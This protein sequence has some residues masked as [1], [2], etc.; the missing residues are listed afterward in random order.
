MVFDSGQHTL[1][2]VRFAG[3]EPGTH[4]LD[5]ELADLQAH[6]EA[7]FVP[8]TVE[9]VEWDAARTRFLLRVSRPED[10]GRY[11]IYDRP[12]DRL[13]Q[14][15]RRT[16]WL[17]ATSLNPGASFSF[18]TPAGIRLSGYVTLPRAPRIPAAAAP[19]LLP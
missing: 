15:M 4:W 9:V 13:V 11:F 17:E 10:P 5:P 8:R 19:D 3:D 16:P 2:G 18:S 1:V 12:N 14:F 7:R 6:L